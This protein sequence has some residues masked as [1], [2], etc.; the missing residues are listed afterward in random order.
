MNSR[1]LHE[2]QFNIIYQK[3]LDKLIEGATDQF[4]IVDIQVATI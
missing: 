4:S 1:N 2:L 3:I